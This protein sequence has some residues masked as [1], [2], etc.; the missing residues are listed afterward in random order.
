MTPCPQSCTP[1]LHKL[2]PSCTP[3]LH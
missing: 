2:P 3:L 1:L